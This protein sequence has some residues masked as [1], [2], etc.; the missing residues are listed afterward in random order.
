[1][2]GDMF[3]EEIQAD[4]SSDLFKI[5]QIPL[6]KVLVPQ[7][8]DFEEIKISFP[9][10]LTWERPL[11]VDERLFTILVIPQTTGNF[12]VRAS[13]A[14]FNATGQGKT[15]EEAMLDIKSAIE[16]LMEEEANPSEG[17]EWPQDYR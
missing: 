5:Q 2:S 17:A 6:A 7:S 8:A 15:E 1:M 11:E 13:T 3:L 14:K 12:V 16:T 4:N 10:F 9:Y